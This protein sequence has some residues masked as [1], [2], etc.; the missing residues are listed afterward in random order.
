MLYQSFPSFL[1]RQ[2]IKL[3]YLLCSHKLQ[4]NTGR[5]GYAQ[6]S[7]FCLSFLLQ[8]EFGPTL[9]SY[10]QKMARLRE[11][12][13]SWLNKSL[14]EN[15]YVDAQDLQIQTRPPRPISFPFISL[16]IFCFLIF[17][18]F[19]ITFCLPHE[20][21]E[22]WN[23]PSGNLTFSFSLNNLFHSGLVQRNKSTHLKTL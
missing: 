16:F 18:E 23:L 7:L 15:F 2:F 11:L 22:D 8:W 19:L 17:L 1:S 10:L 20:K 21:I 13:V 12:L 5:V 4:R 6:I 3:L 9:W 14:R